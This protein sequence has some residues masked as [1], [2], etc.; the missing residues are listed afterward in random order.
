MQDRRPGSIIQGAISNVAPGWAGPSSR[1]A[2]TGAQNRPPIASAAASMA[3]PFMLYEMGIQQLLQAI[4]PTHASYPDLLVYQQ[5][6]LENMRFATRYGDTETLRS[7]RNRVLDYLNQLTVSTLSISFNELSGLVLPQTVSEELETVES[8]VTETFSVRELYITAKLPPEVAI[9]HVFADGADHYCVWGGNA[10]IEGMHTEP[11]PRPDL[12]LADLARSLTGLGAQKVTTFQDRIG[13]FSHSNPKIRGWIKQ[14]RRQFGERLHLI[15]VDYTDFEIPWEMLELAYNEYLGSLVSTVRWQHVIGD[16]DD[17][18]L[19]I[20]LDEC[21]GSVVAY[22]D[23]DAT[24]ARSPEPQL[25]DQL[26]VTTFDDIKLFR[27]CLQRGKIGFS[28]VYIGCH[29]IFDNESSDMALGSPINQQQRLRL[30][31]L[32]RRHLALFEHS[33][34]IV[35]INAAHSGRLRAEERYL[36]DSYR[37]GF[38]ELFLGKGARGVIGTLGEVEPAYAARIARQLIEEMLRGPQ[39][40]VAALLRDL[41]ARVMISLPDDPTDEDVRAL[42]YTFMYVYYG[43]PMA[44]LRL[45]RREG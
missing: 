40:P 38:P 27:D 41:R 24:E 13:E 7:D 2:S 29:G 36:R 6:L 18:A 8:N 5:Q 11:R 17:I 16:D 10:E 9:L 45:K 33:R 25:F 43:N 34:S 15:I 28:L 26:D 42:I 44:V 30:A 37:R 32:R 3:G 1:P 12:A 23:H 20:A 14:L 31:E 22:I 35:F 21:V 19:D 39:R 4:D